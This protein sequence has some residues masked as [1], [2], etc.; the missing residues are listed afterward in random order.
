MKEEITKTI[1]EI[2]DLK[3]DTV[4]IQIKD[5]YEI[6]EN[7]KKKKKKERERERIF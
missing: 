1:K 6:T 3:M 2:V 4:S 7:E 5:L